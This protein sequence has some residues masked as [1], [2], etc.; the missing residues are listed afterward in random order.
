MASSTFIEDLLDAARRDGEQTALLVA[1]NAVDVL[2]A[3]STDF[4]EFVDKWKNAKALYEEFM[5]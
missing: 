4:D 5:T 1:I 2:L 3:H